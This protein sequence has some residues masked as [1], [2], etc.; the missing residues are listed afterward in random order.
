MEDA[1]L[2]V[3]STWKGRPAMQADLEARGFFLP[4]VWQERLIDFCG[5]NGSTGLSHYWDESAMETVCSAG[6]GS[7]DKRKFMVR[8][9]YHSAYLDELAARMDFAEAPFRNPPIHRCLYQH[10]KKSYYDRSFALNET[11]LFES[12]KETEIKSHSISSAGWQGR[13][14][15][16]IPFAR[17]FGAT[18]HFTGKGTTFV[19]KAPGGLRFRCRVDLGGVPDCT[20]TVPLLFDIYH[21]SDPN[22]RYGPISFDRIIPG[23]SKYAYCGSPNSYVLGILAHI[24]LFDLLSKSFQGAA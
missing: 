5:P 22:F 7:P 21:E 11:A 19:K 12:L 2:M 16:V 14:K 6:K 23:F 3:L 1:L 13:K 10:M 4:R 15:D 9:H 20:A 17:Q 24:E 18:R 8:P